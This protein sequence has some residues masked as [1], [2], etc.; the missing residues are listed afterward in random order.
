MNDVLYVKAGQAFQPA[1]PIAERKLFAG[2]IPQIVAVADAVAQAGLHVVIYGERGVGKTS[3]ANILSDL[4]LADMKTVRVSC[5]GEDTFGS[6]WTKL[7]RRL[8]MQQPAAGFQ[9]GQAKLKNLAADLPEEPGPDDIFHLLVKL[10]ARLACIF[11]EFDR[12]PPEH[13]RIF[14]DLIK[15]LSDSAIPATVVIVGV[16]DTVTDLVYEHLSIERAL[17]QVPMPRMQDHELHEI[18]STAAKELEITFTD[19]AM[20]A[21]TRLSQGLPHYTHLLGRD[22]VRAAARQDQQCVSA[23][24][25]REGIRTAI[26]SAQETT[27]EQYARAVQSARQ[28]ALYRQVLL[29][30]ALAEKGERS[31]FRAADVTGPMSKIMGKS[32]DIPAIA[33]HL[34]AF[35][36]DERENVL[37]RSGRPRNYVY[38]FRN[39]LMESYILMRGISEELIRPEDVD[40]FAPAST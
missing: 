27:R 8:Q 6:V 13:A 2:R 10:P 34:K 14:P 4:D 24:H 25:V 12:M 20:K 3:L 28:D 7:A 31:S 18:L 22:S 16:A 17:V 19:N 38:R 30:C 23:K 33:K 9:K 15:A 11:D 35:C 29:A 40:A 36:E 1:T 21:I 32:Y 26:E 5:D 39:P 37:L